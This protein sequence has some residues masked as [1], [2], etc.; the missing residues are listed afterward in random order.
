MGRQ[1]TS[2]QDLAAALA[3]VLDDAAVVEVLLAWERGHR[4]LAW[5]KRP[6]GRRDPYATW[7]AEVMLQQTT[8]AVVAERLPAFLAR[9]P[10]AAALA[11]AG[12]E[13]VVDAWAGLGYYARAR[14]LHR[15]AE[16]IIAR[17]GGRLPAD[18]DAL[19]RLPGIG[20]YTAAAIAALAFGAPVIAL[21]TNVA[22]VLLRLSGQPATVAEARRATGGRLELA[23]PAAARAGALLEAL[24]DLGR[25]IC[26]LRGP[27]C[28]LC[29]LASFCAARRSGLVAEIPARE[30]RRPRRRLEVDAYV[31]RDERDRVFVHRRGS[32]FLKGT[33]CVPLAAAAAQDACGNGIGTG[34]PAAVAW[35]AGA[36][37][38]R[39]LFTHVE[40]VVRPLEG[41]LGRGDPAPRGEGEWL[42]ADAAR[43]RGSTLLR[44]IL[45]AVEAGGGRRRRPRAPGGQPPPSRGSR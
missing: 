24:M 35:R 1:S 10:D 13:A 23:P 14:H 38:V 44:R 33:W 17:H 6:A 20:P 34:P 9:F 11:R 37:V 28:D 32:G 40:L 7:I 39:H 8:V 42:S 43:R 31:L 16:E 21:D 12:V 25:E 18:I 3:A 27:R 30:T 19:A 29:P 15:A 22:R 36:G 4:P 41:R 5:R 26:R 45:D 2:R